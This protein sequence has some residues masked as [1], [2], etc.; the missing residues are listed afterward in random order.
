MKYNIVNV[1]LFPAI[2]CQTTKLVILRPSFT[3]DSPVTPVPACGVERNNRDYWTF[4]G[5]MNIPDKDEFSSLIKV[6]TTT[7]AGVSIFQNK[8]YYY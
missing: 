8:L 4:N 7:S 2:S 1:D 6:K 3:V 5:T